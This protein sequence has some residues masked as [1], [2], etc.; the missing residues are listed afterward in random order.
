MSSIIKATFVL[1]AV[2]LAGALGVPGAAQPAAPTWQ[3]APSITASLDVGG[4]GNFTGVF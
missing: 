1:G 3:P 2:T 4:S